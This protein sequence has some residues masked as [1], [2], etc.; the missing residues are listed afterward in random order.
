MPAAVAV[1][2][3]LVVPPVEAYLVLS[4]WTT[5]DIGVN[6]RASEINVLRI[7]LPALLIAHG[8]A[9]GLLTCA[10]VLLSRSTRWPPLATV[11]VLV[12]VTTV[13]AHL[14]ATVVA[15]HPKPDLSCA[16][17]IP[18]WWPSWLPRAGFVGTWL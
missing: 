7:G 8:V 11:V 1:V 14:V 9:L 4:A 5:C 17:G 10:G 6:I 13:G 18:P 15:V 12:A 2:L 16:L 3:T